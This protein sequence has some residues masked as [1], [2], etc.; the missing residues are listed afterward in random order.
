MFIP[1]C[2]RRGGTPSPYPLRA[3]SDPSRQRLSVF[4]FSAFQLFS[5][6]AFSH[7]L[8]HLERI[9]RHQHRQVRI[10][11]IFAVAPHDLAVQ[12]QI[13]AP[14]LRAF[15]AHAH[16]DQASG[17][18]GRL[19]T[20]FPQIPD[21]QFVICRDMVIGLVKA[22]PF[23]PLPPDIDARRKLSFQNFHCHACGSARANRLHSPQS[24]SLTLSAK[25]GKPIGCFHNLQPADRFRL[26][27]ILHHLVRM[28]DL[29]FACQIF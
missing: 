28:G 16:R 19:Q 24:P 20:G 13:A 3:F 25:H 8:P 26:P 14:A 17:Q 10:H 7:K 5:F 29:E 1:Y 21:Q 2:L 18:I 6:S 23:K 4:S 12:Q 22:E 9:L 15:A 11:P 27:Q